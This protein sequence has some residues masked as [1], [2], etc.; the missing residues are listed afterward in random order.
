[1]NSQRGAVL[2]TSLI[3]LLIITAIAISTLSSGTFQTVMT[4]NAQQ[5]QTVLR[6]AETITEDQLPL[7]VAVANQ[8]FIAQKT[9]DSYSVPSVSV[10]QSNIRNPGAV[11][12]A[13]SEARPAL[14]P[15]VQLSTSGVSYVVRAYEVRGS[16]ATSDGKIG[17][18]VVVGVGRI[19]T[20]VN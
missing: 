19:E 13:Q 3:L 6:V 17:T 11:V 8:A 18:T 20:E 4:T 10:S 15:G 16:A 7:T 5:R 9:G 1:M 2:V 12:Q 14:L